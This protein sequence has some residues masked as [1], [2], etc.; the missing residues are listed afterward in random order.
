M[1]NISKSRSTNAII[2][3]CIVGAIPSFLYHQCLRWL[4]KADLKQLFH[5]ITPTIWGADSKKRFPMI[6]THY[7]LPVLNRWVARTA[8]LLGAMLW[9]VIGVQ[10]QGW[11]KYF[12]GPGNDGG[13]AVVETSD[14]GFLA[15]GSYNL[16]SF[17]FVRTDENG[18]LLWSKHIDGSFPSEARA[19]VPVA[20]GF[21]A[22]GYID[23]VGNGQR[24]VY[25]LKIDPQ[26]NVLW[27]QTYG[28]G[29]DDEGLGAQATS[30]GG[31]IITGYTEID[32]NGK[33]ILLL[34]TDSLGSTEWVKTFG[35]TGND[36]GKS[37]VT[38]T[39]GG[40]AITG[41][42]EVSPG[43]KNIYLVK[44]DL[45]GSQ[46]WGSYYGALEPDFGYAIVQTPD[47]G[48]VIAGSIGTSNQLY[49]LKTDAAG[50]QQWERYYG[51]PGEDF[52]Y[53]L[54]RTMDGGFIITGYSDVATGSK[55][56]LVRT[57]SNGLLKWEKRF[58]KTGNGV[59]EI[60]VSVGYCV[61]ET[62]DGSFIVAGLANPNI[63][64]F[65]VD[66]NLYL[67]KT[68]SLGNTLNSYLSGN[69]F[70][71]LN[72]NCQREPNELPLQGWIVEASGATTYF[73]TT[74][75]DG[76]YII[77]V[78][79]GD[80]HVSLVAPN[81]YWESCQT[82]YNV[83][84]NAPYDTLVLPFAVH[85]SISC[86]YMVVDV[87]TS[88][89]R[90]CAENVY[91]INYCNR[92]TYPALGAFVEVVLDSSLTYNSSSL[93]WSYNAGH[94]Y[95]FN[96]GNVFPGECNSF[97]INATLECNGTEA[98][99]THCVSAHI[100][101]D[102]LCNPPG[103]EWNGSSIKVNAT[104]ENDSIFFLIQNT[105]NGPIVPAYNLKYIIIEDQVL[106]LQ[107]PIDNLNPGETQQVHIAALPGKTYRL[108]ADQSPGHPGDSH[109]TVAVEGCNVNGPISIGYVTMFPE[110]DADPFVD[111]DCKESVDVYISNEKVA[112]P[113]GYGDEHYIT[114]QTDL[115]YLIHFQNTG[116]DTAMNI[117]VI[118]TLSQYLDPVSIQ[119]G[120]SSHPYHYEVYGNG[121][122]R[123]TFDQALL[124]DSSSNEPASH[125]FVKFRISQKPDN[126]GGTVIL[127]RATVSINYLAPVVTNETIHRVDSN[128][129]IVSTDELPGDIARVIRVYPN[130]F[131]NT[132]TID[133]GDSNFSDISLSL[134]DVTGRLLRRE[135]FASPRFQ[136]DRKGLPSG[137]Y[138]FRL[139]TDGRLIGNGKIIVN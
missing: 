33:D 104:C 84:A 35:G 17:Y 4:V 52:G 89:L 44:T 99:Q 64:N 72:N 36:E 19:L 54:A 114:D 21:V 60:P 75:T 25:L 23:G 39:D 130:P 81:N 50:T 117:V 131:V 34:K 61:G 121:I 134:F 103:A 28:N 1:Q 59:D 80:Y 93:P 69:V 105:G 11:E 85:T 132:T 9:C 74:D 48:F 20:D 15:A 13:Y 65:G 79:T 43:N 129:V 18:T 107:Q 98:G 78:D 139:E 126:P 67:F 97:Q 95:I 30:D 73:G 136:F 7:T 101:P 127:N 92:G 109:P 26:G 88:F 32:G 91:S 55:A 68:D 128:Y 116:T 24:D 71:D 66:D 37:V 76:N 41:A 31:L 27:T 137:V 12:G 118:D 38:T 29:M 94:H 110:D 51:G 113:K 3:L 119:P 57:D 47:G 56:Y 16:T 102:S 112:H 124:P 108:V 5:E 63:N 123:F 83:S 96:L 100:Y 42:Y 86:P 40:Y 135:H 22:V 10:A 90:R 8:F 2:C 77:P 115:E 6:I 62:S 120:A 49:L 106:F 14:G 70:H 45:T 87:S 138:L 46:Q 53:S 125:G 82:G 133:L 58:G 122:V 111:I